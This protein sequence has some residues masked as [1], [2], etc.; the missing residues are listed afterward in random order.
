MDK[1]MEQI[2]REKAGDESL[3]EVMDF[4]QQNDP[5]PVVRTR[6][7]LAKVNRPLTQREKEKLARHKKRTRK[8]NKEA[9]FQM[10]A[11]AKEIE[12]KFHL[13]L[14]YRYDKVQWNIQAVGG[15]PNIL[16]ELTWD[17]MRSEQL[18]LQGDMCFMD[19]YVLDV[20]YS[21]GN[22][23]EGDVR[24][25]DY[26]LD[27][28]QGEYSRSMSD[29]EGGDV[30]DLMFGLG[31]RMDIDNDRILRMSN[32]DELTVTLLGGYSINE[33][34]LVA[35]DGFQEVPFNGPEGLETLHSKYVTEWKGPWF[36]FELVGRRRKLSG[37]FRYQYHIADYYAWADWNLR[38]D[39]QHPKSFEHE[40]TA[41]GF[42]INLGAKY[43]LK[44][45]FSLDLA[46]DF[47]QWHTAPGV[48]RTFFSS[49]T[50]TETRLNE[51]L[52]DSHAFMFGG[53][54]YFD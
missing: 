34:D 4:V 7:D 16:S 38:S 24:D 49:G 40:A 42:K 5:K 46:M 17:D 10:P 15:T 48:D 6:E 41:R 19:H 53:T 2:A 37:V 25:S 33:Q 14:G 31:Y 3:D 47:Q 11:W 32:C 13:S 45:Y 51:V 39:F 18:T 43:H 12:S 30:Y 54:F 50:V 1:A 26:A 35:E 52:W 8:L 27:G 29:A 28:R 44:E 21:T 9:F 23:Q 22:I 20:L 36:G